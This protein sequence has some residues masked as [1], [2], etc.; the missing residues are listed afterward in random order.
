M[1]INLKPLFK[2]YEFE[3]QYA[4]VSSSKKDN[5]TFLDVLKSRDRQNKK[6]L[7]VYEIAAKIA[8]GETVRVEELEYIKE[9][10]TE[11]YKQA[12]LICQENK[13]HKSNKNHIKS[14]FIVEDSLNNSIEKAE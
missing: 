13:K 11:L 4:N 10:S 14:L 8:K 6:K 5:I 9:N 1:K 12:L 2:E 7:N 3:K